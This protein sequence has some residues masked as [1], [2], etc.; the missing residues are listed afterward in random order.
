MLSGIHAILGHRGSGKSR[1]ARAI[2]SESSQLII[3]DTLDEHSELAELVTW[4]QL[5]EKLLREPVAYRFRIIPSGIEEVELIERAAAARV[6]CCLFIDEIDWWYTD[7]RVPVGEGLNSLVRY[8]RHY[9]QSVVAIARR[10]ADMSRTITSQATLWCFP[11]REPRDRKYV[12]GF[13]DLD[14]GDLTILEEREGMFIRTQLARVGTRGA[15]I[16]E[17]N[18]ETGQYLFQDGT[19]FSPEFA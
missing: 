10:P 13:A 2:V 19:S 16:G 18:L 4:D 17:F 12:Q 7:A 1:L 8:G 14:P 15:E 9:E 5:S 11:M 6:G 3:I